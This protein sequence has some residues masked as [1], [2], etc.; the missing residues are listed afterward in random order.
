MYWNYHGPLNPPGE[1]VLFGLF[2]DAW[3][4]ESSQRASNQASKRWQVWQVCGCLDSKNHLKVIMLA[5]QKHPFV[6]EILFGG[7]PYICTTAPAGSFRWAWYL[8]RTCCRVNLM[9]SCGLSSGNCSRDS[10]VRIS[11]AMTNGHK[12]NVTIESCSGKISKTLVTAESAAVTALRWD[13]EAMLKRELAKLH[14]GEAGQNIQWKE[15]V[16]Q[17]KPQRM[18]TS[19]WMPLVHSEARRDGLCKIPRSTNKKGIGSSPVTVSVS[20]CSWVSNARL[21][22]F[23]KNAFV[24]EIGGLRLCSYGRKSFQWGIKLSV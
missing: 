11:T 4:P 7:L 9:R 16:T 8:C 17:E 1:A 24:K 10:G 12:R 5:I 19:N 21:G 22:I 23:T 3:Y 2:L 18:F 15:I 20:E 14:T 13:E 6:L